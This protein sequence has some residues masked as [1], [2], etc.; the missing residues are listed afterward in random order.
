MPEAD[1]TQL[2][3]AILELADNPNRTR[4]LALQGA[5]SVREKY[6]ASYLA[7]RFANLISRAYEMRG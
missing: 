2:G 4:E 7:E 1:P 3:R 5:A 6:D